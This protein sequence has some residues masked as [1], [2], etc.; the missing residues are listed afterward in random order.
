MS[1]S[2]PLINDAG[3][4]GLLL[5]GVPSL[6]HATAVTTVKKKEEKRLFSCII[7]K[8]YARVL[9]LLLH[10]PSKALGW[11]AADVDVSTVLLSSISECT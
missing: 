1:G 7:S 9:G 6:T 8:F 11:P 2:H 3:A 10:S 5:G 4:A